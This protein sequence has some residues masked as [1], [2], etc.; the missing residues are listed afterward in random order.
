MRT[1]RLNQACTFR[2][3]TDLRCSLESFAVVKCS[4]AA[5]RRCDV[6]VAQVWNGAGHDPLSAMFSASVQD[7]GSTGRVASEFSCH[8]LS[9]DPISTISIRRKEL[10]DP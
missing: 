9:T 3:T 2:I 5:E 8:F 1:A 7:A 6:R 10:V 4:M